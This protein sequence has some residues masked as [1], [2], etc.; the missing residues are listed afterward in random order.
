MEDVSDKVEFG[1]DKNGSYEIAVPLS[2]L[3]LEPKPGIR[4]KGDIGILRGNGKQT[5]QRVYWTNKATA[6]V[7]D[8]P[9]EAE[10]TP[11]LWG[12][13]EFGQK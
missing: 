4:I 5:T 1:E 8:V 3:G 11:K 10:L 9:S 13:W 2:V 6:I 12:T 7:S